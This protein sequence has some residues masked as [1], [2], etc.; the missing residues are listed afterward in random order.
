MIVDCHVHIG[1]SIYGYGLTPADLLLQMDDLAIDRAI[2]CP[3][4]PQDYHL[5]PANDLVAA[6]VRAHPDRFSGF[7]RVDPRRGA[8]ALRELE[9]AAGELGLQGLFLHPWEEGYP[10]DLPLVAPVVELATALALP[11]MVATGYPW[12]S[13][14]TQV[15]EL[16][17]R[18]PQAQVVMTHGGQINISGLAQADA[19]AALRASPNLRTEVSGTYRQDFIEDVIAELGAERVLFGSNAPRFS[20]A[21]ELERIRS[22]ELDDRQRQ[23]VLGGNV[24]RLLQ[25]TI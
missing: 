10:L 2:L 17:R 13:H 6:A 11:I 1:Q 4:Q 14:A 18:H 9:R 8:Y 24:A 23:A 15:Q 21:F 5:E 12:V 22:L 7:C 3:V 20:Q 16:C 19:F 25:R